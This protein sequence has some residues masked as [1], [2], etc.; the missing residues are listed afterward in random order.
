[1]L[2]G[3][4]AG[5]AA[6]GPVGQRPRMGAFWDDEE[7]GPGYHRQWWSPPWGCSCFQHVD[8]VKSTWE[9]STEMMRVEEEGREGPE[10]RE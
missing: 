1:M 10:G 6:E 4:G 2:K 7:L 9:E 8:G 5:S 3:R